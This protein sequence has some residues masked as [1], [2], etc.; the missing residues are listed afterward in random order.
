MQ[1]QSGTGPSKQRHLIS[2]MATT[3]FGVLLVCTMPLALAQNWE[4]LTV[5]DVDAFPDDEHPRFHSQSK[6]IFRGP[7]GASLIWARFNP[8]FDDLPPGSPLGRHYHH[9]HEWALVLEGDY[10]IHEP[11]SPR[12]KH[13]PLY[14]FV[15]GTWLDRPA[16]SIHGGTWAL[17]GMRSQRPCTLLIFEE[18]DGSVVTL[19][20]DGDH[21]KPDF[22][23]SKPSPYLPDWASVPSFANPW[24]VNSGSQLEW[25]PDEDQP[26][27]WVKWLSD[28]SERGFR[29]RLIMVAPGW[30]SQA[31][32]NAAWYEKANRFLYV[33]WGDLNIQQ[34]D[35]A[36]SA[37][38]LLSASSDWFIHQPPRALFSHGQ[39]PVS[40]GG[41]IW[42]EVTYADGITVGG[43]PIETVKTLP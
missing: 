35:D 4:S 15:E 42:L 22:P 2:A 1:H 27:R 25:E 9:F 31:S 39:G 3:L 12:Q 41:A 23:D 36:G 11:V 37:S 38:A 32:A 8:R 30:S 29:A 24:I 13:G 40:E 18:G 43:G 5:V 6:S 28:D 17:G 16:Y 14:Q 21:F 20:A 26:G 33:V 10:V 19:G 34:Y 7:G